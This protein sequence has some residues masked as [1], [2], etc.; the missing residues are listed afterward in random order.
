MSK[1]ATQ[2]LILAAGKSS[3][4]IPYNEYGHKS[5]QVLLG[6]PII[7]WTLEAL[8]KAKI[9]DVVVVI[10]AGNQE[11]EKLIKAYTP[12]FSQLHFT[13]QKKALGMA[14]AIL[15]AQPY[16]HD[17]FFVLNANKIDAD[18]HLA[19]MNQQ[20]SEVVLTGQPTDKAELYGVLTL[21]GDQATSLIEKPN[22][23]V[24]NPVRVIGVYLLSRL[25][26]NF[27]S[28]LKK[29]EYLLEKALNQY[30]QKEIVKVVKFS[31]QISS[32]KY[33]WHLLEIKDL[34]F[35]R[36]QYHISA[37][38]Q[39]SPTSQ[40]RGPV[41]IDDE[42]I[43]GDF[44][45]VEGPA[46]IGKRA[47]VGRYAVIRSKSVLEAGAEVQSYAEIKNSILMAGAH[48]HSGFIGDSIIG[49]RTRIGA[50]F[51][52]ANRRLDRKNI[53]VRI[54]DKIVDSRRTFLGTI[55]GYDAKIGI[56]VSTMPNVIIGNRVMVEPGEIIKKDVYEKN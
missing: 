36:L 1:N 32:L 8:K 18:L 29:E 48:L 20:S 51:I 47:V 22:Y 35:P 12:A 40:I 34:L 6:K 17:R 37:T 9:D 41:F 38:A 10:N 27:M 2:A 52:T 39:I 5:Q 49:Q 30:L 45:I 53:K 16:L 33:P 11:L 42:A 46:Y 31:G 25:F 50:G 7:Y 15:T 21:E 44:A 3:R 4:F 19:D 55:I 26:I 43:I 54:K 23:S 24:K 14:D 28:T 56:R 13:Y